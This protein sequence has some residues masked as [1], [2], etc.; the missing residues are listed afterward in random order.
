MDILKKYKL[1]GAIGFQNMVRNLQGMAPTKRQQILELSFLEDPPFTQWIIKNLYDIDIIFTIGG[2]YFP[3]LFEL[4]Q[5]KLDLFV[6][7]FYQTDLEEK[8]LE[9]FLDEKFHKQY[10]ELCEYNKHTASAIVQAARISLLEKIRKLQDDKVITEIRWEI[11][12]ESI[13]KG[14][15]A[16]PKSGK[17][18]Y[19]FEDGSVALEG[20]FEEKMRE[21]QWKH[22]FSEG[23]IMAEGFYHQGQKVDAWKFYFPNGKIRMEGH[24]EENL[25]EGNWKVYGADDSLST[26]EYKRGKI[27]N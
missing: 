15:L 21:G 8:F 11:P 2:Q 24:Y 12:K 19:L 17:F 5:N 25:K 14:M 10:K 4:C 3:D 9:E 20:N 16:V 13:L 6:K 26:V 7:A 1:K 27:E 23:K 22:Y 18:E